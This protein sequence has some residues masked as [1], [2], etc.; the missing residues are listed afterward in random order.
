MVKDPE[1]VKIHVNILDVE[2]E[3]KRCVEVVKLKG[4]RFKFSQAY[5]S[6]KK[7]FSES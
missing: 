5:D 3:G 1:N 6:L 4:D 2:D 7:F